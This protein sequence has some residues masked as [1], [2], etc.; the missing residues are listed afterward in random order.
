MLPEQIFLLEKLM[1]WP[2]SLSLEREW[3]RRNEVVEAVRIY[4]R[5]REG[6]PR[7][8]RRPKNPTCR[9]GL[10]LYS[11]PTLASI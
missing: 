10:S 7:R 1:I 3:K 2:T 4:C 11:A 6:R 5:V 8:G 9:D